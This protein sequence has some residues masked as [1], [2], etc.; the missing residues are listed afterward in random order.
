MNGKSERRSCWWMFCQLLMGTLI[1][2]SFSTPVRAFVGEPSLGGDV[3]GDAVFDVCLLVTLAFPAARSL[4]FGFV[5]VVGVIDLV[6]MT[7]VPG[8][9]LN[10]WSMMPSENPNLLDNALQ[11]K[12]RSNRGRSKEC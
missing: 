8:S 3:V 5:F 11:M 9:W 2:F 7:A 6:V 10:D 4:G 1:S 12:E